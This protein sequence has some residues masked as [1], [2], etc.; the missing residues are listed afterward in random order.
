MPNA[1]LPAFSGVTVPCSMQSCFRQVDSCMNTPPFSM[2]I[3]FLQSCCSIMTVW[4]SLSD[5]SLYSSSPTYIFTLSPPFRA[6]KS[7]YA[8]AQSS[9]AP[10]IISMSFLPVSFI[11]EPPYAL[12]I[13]PYVFR[14]VLQ[15]GAV[16][17]LYEHRVPIPQAIIQ[18]AHYILAGIE[19]HGLDARA[20]RLFAGVLH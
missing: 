11:K 4:S 2:R 9:S 15:L 14:N 12:E 19:V 3:T 6:P 1:L 16:G 7:R 17:G 20:L 10:P 8:T 13:F 18:G 5:I